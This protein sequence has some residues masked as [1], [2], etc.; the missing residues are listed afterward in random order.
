VAGS[1]EAG[2]LLCDGRAVSRTTYARLF[3]KIGTTHGAGDGASTFNLPDARGRSLIGAG[4]G[5]G[6][7]ART[8]GAKGGVE[9]HAI[10][11]A[12]MPWH[13]HTVA[14]HNHG[15]GW[16]GHNVSGSIFQ[17]TPGHWYDGYEQWMNPKGGFHAFDDTIPMN[18]SVDGAAPIG[19]EAPGTDGRGG[20]AA[21]NNMSPWLAVSVLIKT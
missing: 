14:A 9:V 3:A 2:W 1:E 17:P 13:G 4:Q 8:L 5:S 12:E 11:E 16:H 18:F 15:G 21:H 20:N 6:L 7:T 19:T 10:T